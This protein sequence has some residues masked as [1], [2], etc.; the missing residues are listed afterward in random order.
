MPG[1]LP[2]GKPGMKA[3]QPG[4]PTILFLVSTNVIAISKNGF[5]Q[6]L[7]I[8]ANYHQRKNHCQTGPRSSPFPDWSRE[9]PR[10]EV[11]GAE[12]PALL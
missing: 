9:P 12:Q 6:Q 3:L 1:L 8:W 10:G 4:N 5:F 7:Q 2:R 11:T